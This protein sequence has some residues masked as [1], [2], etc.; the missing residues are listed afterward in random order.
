M[1]RTFLNADPIGVARTVASLV[2]HGM[3]RIALLGV[4]RRG[5]VG[6]MAVSNTDVQVF[7]S[8][9]HDD[10][11]L[12]HDLVKLLGDC[13]DLGTGR[14]RVSS[15]TGHQLDVGTSLNDQLRVEIASAAVLALVTPRS[16]K[17]DWF[18]LELGA[19]WGLERAILPLLHGVSADRLPEP[20]KHRIYT[21][22]DDSN[23]VHHLIDTLEKTLGWKTKPSG[24]VRSAVETFVESVR[25]VGMER[26]PLPPEQP[27]SVRAFGDI[28]SLFQSHVAIH[29]VVGEAPVLRNRGPFEVVE[30][31]VRK[32][33]QQIAAGLEVNE[34]VAIVDPDTSSLSDRPEVLEYKV[35]SY[36][37]L[38]ALRER[39]HRVGGDMPLVLSGIAP[40]VNAAT[41]HLVVQRRSNGGPGVST[42]PGLL[43][44]VGGLF[45]AQGSDVDYREDPDIHYTLEREIFE[46]VGAGPKTSMGPWLIIEDLRPGFLQVGPSVVEWAPSSPRRPRMI[47]GLAVELPPSDLRASVFDSQAWTPGSL[48]R[49]LYWLAIGAPGGSDAYRTLLEDFD[50]IA[51]AIRK[52]AVPEEP[53]RLDVVGDDVDPA[54]TG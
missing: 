18:K 36:A 28:K 21:R 29:A 10:P 16:L 53:F 52:G 19:A 20:L 38:L 26:T 50:D 54:P 14:V 43:G 35:A 25:L 42:Y 2:G 12:V 37:D 34:N 51:E 48:I 46:E 31:V 11:Q 47:E 32:R 39:V 15:V 22:I 30:G 40:V 23:D 5:I 49:V 17:S 44:V 6:D 3:R 1:N 33:A 4:R 9:S 27:S 45:R 24:K 13:F 8:H 41:G 7:V